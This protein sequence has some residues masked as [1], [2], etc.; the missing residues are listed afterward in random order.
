MILTQNSK[1]LNTKAKFCANNISSNVNFT[2]IECFK[3]KIGFKALLEKSVSYN[4]HHNAKHTTGSILDFIIDSSIL[5]FSRFILYDWLWLL[6][7]PQ[8][9][10]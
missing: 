9:E 5:G 1:K 10:C 3:N 7:K 4:K 6:F 8:S 2:F